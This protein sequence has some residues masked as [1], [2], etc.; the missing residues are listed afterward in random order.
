MGIAFF[1]SSNLSPASYCSCVLW[2][3]PHPAFV[4]DEQRQELFWPASTSRGLLNLKAAVRCSLGKC[5]MSR[6]GLG[7][8]FWAP[9]SLWLGSLLH[10]LCIVGCKGP[11]W[12][13]FKMAEAV[14]MVQGKP[15]HVPPQCP[16][17]PAGQIFSLWSFPELQAVLPGT[18]S[19]RQSSLAPFSSRQVLSGPLSSFSLS[20]FYEAPYR[21]EHGSPSILL[22]HSCQ[23]KAVMG[24]R[25]QGEFAASQQGWKGQDWCQ[26]TGG[27]SFVN[28]FLTQGLSDSVFPQL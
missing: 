14:S 20:F 6:Q 16:S 15:T 23:H 3:L 26:S 24:N 13:S 21:A 1:L 27:L 2:S 11:L 10:S 22:S 9:P 18:L 4:C 12:M 28:G 5:Y 19:S 8:L 17:L 25:C 7:T